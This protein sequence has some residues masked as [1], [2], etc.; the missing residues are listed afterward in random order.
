MAKITPHKGGRSARINVRATAETKQALETIARRNDETTA[1][2]VA[3]MIRQ[4]TKMD[5]EKKVKMTPT[6]LHCENCG[7]TV[8]AE[9]QAQA[10]APCGCVWV[11]DGGYINSV[12]YLTACDPIEDPL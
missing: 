5:T 1:D 7:K 11:W 9:Y 8:Q 12:P 3:R 10:P 4:E 6:G 2:A